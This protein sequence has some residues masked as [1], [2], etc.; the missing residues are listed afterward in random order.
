VVIQQ[1]CHMVANEP[2]DKKQ[3]L[4]TELVKNIKEVIFSNHDLL[5]S[6]SSLTSIK[7]IKTMLEDSKPNSRSYSYSYSQQ[8]KMEDDMD[9]ILIFME[10]ELNITKLIL[11]NLEAYCAFINAKIKKEQLDV[12]DR[13]KI[14]IGKHTHHDEIDERLKFLSFCTSLSYLPLLVGQVS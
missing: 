7:M 14:Y 13:K 5:Q 8:Q 11:I 3:P 4:L 2:L 6:S 9:A 12:S 10:Q 1:F